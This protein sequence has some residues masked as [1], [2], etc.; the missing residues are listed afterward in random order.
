MRRCLVIPRKMPSPIPNNMRDA[1]ELIWFDEM[2]LI[3]SSSTKPLVHD[4]HTRITGIKKL[5]TYLTCSRRNCRRRGENPRGSALLGLAECRTTPQC[6]L[7][8]YSTMCQCVDSLRLGTAASRSRSRRSSTAVSLFD[9][10]SWL[11][12]LFYVG[13]EADQLSLLGAICCGALFCLRLLREA[14]GLSPLERF[15]MMLSLSFHLS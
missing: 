14:S 4:W 15:A 12:L 9:F 6:V 13:G 3:E 2:K 5:Q 10:R 11:S 8:C 7:G 1:A